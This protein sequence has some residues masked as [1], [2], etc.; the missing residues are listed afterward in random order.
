MQMA[1][2]NLAAVCVLVRMSNSS[3]VLE[4]EI[5]SIAPLPEGILSGHPGHTGRGLPEWFS[6]RQRAAWAEFQRLPM[7]ARTDQ[8][9]RFS[10]VG[11]LDLSP[12]HQAESPSNSESREILERSVGAKTAGRLVFAN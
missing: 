8:A 10:N 12:F 5:A 9:W 11:A 6:K 2:V 7:P 3:A 4:E 1:A